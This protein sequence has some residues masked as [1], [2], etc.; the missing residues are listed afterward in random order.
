MKIVH[1]NSKCWEMWR[2]VY[3]CVSGKRAKASS[4]ECRFKKNVQPENAVDDEV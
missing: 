2:C 4:R 1:K 3:L